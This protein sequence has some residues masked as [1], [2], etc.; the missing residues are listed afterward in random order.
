MFRIGDKIVKNIWY[1]TVGVEKIFYGTI[2]VYQ[3]GEPVEETFAITKDISTFTGVF[4]WVF[5]KSKM[6]WYR[7]NNLGKY[8]EYGI[9]GTSINPNPEL[10]YG[11]QITNGYYATQVTQNTK[12]R[13]EADFTTP[14]TMTTN[15]CFITGVRN[16][17]SSSSTNQTYCIAVMG[18]VLRM[19][20]GNTSNTNLY[21][22]TENTRYKVLYDLDGTTLNWSIADREGNVLASGTKAIS[23]PAT[24][25]ANNFA[26]GA[27]SRTGTAPVVSPQQYTYWEIKYYKDDVLVADYKF[28]ENQN[29]YDALSSYST[30][31]GAGTIVTKED[32]LGGTTTYKGKLSIVDGTEYKYDGGWNEIGVVIGGVYPE[33]YEVV[34]APTLIITFATQAEFE[35]YTGKVIE[36]QMAFVAETETTYIRHNNNWEVFVCEPIICKNH[37]SNNIYAMPTGEASLTSCDYDLDGL[38]TITIRTGDAKSFGGVAPFFDTK[39]SLVTT[40]TLEDVDLRLPDSVNILTYAFCGDGNTGVKHITLTNAKSLTYVR[41]SFTHLPKLESLYIDSLE[42]ATS[43]LSGLPGT[44]D[45]K[46]TD[47]YIGKFPDVDFTFNAPNLSHASLINMLNALPVSTGHGWVMGSGN[48]AK[49]SADE[50]QIATDKG[51]TIQ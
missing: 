49:L 41:A 43:M 9:Y 18:K 33:Y 24:S 8:E 2:L 11:V 1:G 47:V 30:A 12:M 42:N 38:K 22:V 15:S 46:L 23:S 39:P 19:D 21:T 25:T 26:I 45:V 27:L 50:I 4:D 10:Q 37:M 35:S 48:L 7:L 32:Y 17:A 31:A 3:N 13:I 6:K 28:D 44:Y 29:M 36:G 20:A 14:E 16:A 5:D 34:D 51:W 40:T